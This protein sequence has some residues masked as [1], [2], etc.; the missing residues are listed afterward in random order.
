MNCFT[1]VILGSFIA[2][3]I[4]DI[5][6]AHWWSPYGELWLLILVAVGGSS[7]RSNRVNATLLFFYYIKFFTIH[8]IFS[9]KS[10]KIFLAL[11]KL[12]QGISPPFKNRGSAPVWNIVWISSLCYRLYIVHPL[13]VFWSFMP[14]KYC[15]IVVFPVYPFINNI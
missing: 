14:L 4:C 12:Y 3:W 6:F 13:D 11:Y 8:I 5:D 15:C 9:R 10:S 2:D 1:F 7:G